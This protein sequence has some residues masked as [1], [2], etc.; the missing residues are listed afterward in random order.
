MKRL[1]S[2]ALALLSCLAVSPALAQEH[3]TDGPVWGVSFY[4]TKPGK[5]DDYVKWLRG[6]YLSV[7]AEEKA[8]GLI[9]DSKVF[10]NSARTSPTDWDICVAT[11]FPSY[12]KALDYSASDEAKFKAIAAKQFKTPDEQK[13]QEMMAPRFEMR[14]YLGTKYIR[15]VTLKPLAH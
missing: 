15:E 3:W 14:E 2:L 10:I 5:F 6:N 1:A 8:Q 12:G 4:Q 7:V 13:Q 9:L 11:L